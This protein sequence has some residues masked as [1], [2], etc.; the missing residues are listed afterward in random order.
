M[1]L[2]LGET[3]VRLLCAIGHINH[4]RLVL[5]NVKIGLSMEE[6]YVL[7]KTFDFLKTCV[8]CILDIQR[9]GASYVKQK[10][11]VTILIFT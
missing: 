9:F 6:F 10:K 1:G 11:K 7:Y 3:L 8:S 2:S 5:K 4:G